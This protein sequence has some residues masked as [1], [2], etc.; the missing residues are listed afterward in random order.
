MIQFFTGNNVE[1]LKQFQDNHFHACVTDPPYGLKFM[2]KKWDYD[3]PSLEQCQE[4]LRVL[5]PGAYVVAYC[6]TRTYHRMVVNFEDAGFE[7]RDQLAWV[8]GQGFPK[9]ANGEWGGSALKP[10]WEPIMLARKPLEGTLE[11]NF[12]KWG[13]GG[14]DIDG[15]RIGEIGARNNGR[16][17]D[18][19]IYG[20]F[21]PTQKQDYNKGRW[22]ANLMHD[23]S[24]EVVNCFPEAKDQQGDLKNHSKQRKSPN[25]VFSEM[26]PAK[27]HIARIEE[28]KSAARFFYCPKASK[29][30][31]NEGCE[32]FET[33]QTTGGGGGIGN[34][35][36]DVNAASGKFGSEKAPQQNNHPT[37]KPTELMQW[38]IRLVTPKNG[39]ILD[40]WAG[41]GSTGKAAAIENYSAILIDMDP[42]WKPIAEAR[43][44]HVKPKDVIPNKNPQLNLFQ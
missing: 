15:C 24:D 8:Y 27:D 17:K 21:G 1:V 11:Q 41:S 5:R 10:A 2:A 16:K 19:D 3:V 26:P 32:N 12:K 35:L 23:G 14:L 7:I 13:T 40:P 6:G 43:I 28:S 4:I 9:S 36:T 22:P 20:N 33:K 30:D 37:V 44:N 34:Y 25:G 31:R 42:Q 29:K 38:L 39:I 18:S